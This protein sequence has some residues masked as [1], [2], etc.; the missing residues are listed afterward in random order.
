MRDLAEPVPRKSK[1]SKGLF[2]GRRK[3]PFRRADAWAS[4][5][6]D[7]RWQ[8]LEIRAGSKGPLQVKAIRTQVQTR[9][10]GRLGAD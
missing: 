4:R 5:Q 10:Q 1:G 3:P 7:N 8:E 2:R 9:D 6:P